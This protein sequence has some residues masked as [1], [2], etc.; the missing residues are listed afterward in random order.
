MVLFRRREN[1]LATDPSLHRLKENEEKYQNGKSPKVF[2]FLFYFSN[3][4]FFL[5]RAGSRFTMSL[6][7][8]SEKVHFSK[9]PKKSP[10]NTALSFFCLH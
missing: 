8:P 10:Q 4:S 3:S 5:A 1:R 6:K 9:E 2:L 7:V